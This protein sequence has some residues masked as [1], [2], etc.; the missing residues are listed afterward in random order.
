MEVFV[1]KAQIRTA[2]RNLVNEQSTDAGALMPTGDSI[3]D[4]Y[5]EDAVEEVV[6]D[7]L[8]YIPRQF[9]GTENISLTANTAGYTLTAEWFQIYKI[10]RNTT[11]KTPREIQI[12]DTLEE[13]FYTSVGDTEENPSHCY[14]LGDTITF[15]KTPSTDKT[16]YAK[17]FF[18]RPEAV[19][20]PDTG[21]AYIPRAA[22]RMIVYKACAL[23]CVMIEAIAGNFTA[24]Y[25]KRKAAFLRTWAGREHQ[26]SRFV[27]DS[28]C[29]RI[30][31]S[32]REAVFFDLDWSD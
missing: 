12:I 22:H 14:I 17:V 8:P 27:K 16:N 10:A 9:C 6:L 15:V 11:G 21:P 30:G 29:D 20:M 5:I 25:E 13:Q 7:L 32:D 28:V 26:S 2:I 19:T 4:N 24:L 31:Y 1:T 3:I 23:A 18:V